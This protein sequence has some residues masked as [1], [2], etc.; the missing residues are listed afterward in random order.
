ML[1]ILYSFRRCPY[2]MRAR[3]AL[4]YSCISYEHR[5]I[6]LRDRPK[7]L[8]ELSPKGTVPVLNL[9][10]GKVLEESLDIM[11]WAINKN[12]PDD[13]YCKNKE[14]QDTLIRNNDQIFKNKLD[15]YKY[16]IRHTEK[17]FDEH[18]QNIAKL[19]SEHDDRLAQ[20]NYL[21]GDKITLA[22]V[23]IMPFIRQC[24]F[25]DKNWFDEEFIHLSNWLSEL[26]ESR[27]FTSV[28]HKYKIWQ[29]GSKGIIK[30]GN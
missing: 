27:L 8:Y 10:D 11:K 22:D 19:L 1:P 13:W 15:K 23:A 28:M 7:S 9:F 21:I 30:N 16:H 26:L 25:V 14:D 4:F 17:T 2:A 29:E 5:E 12:D 3:M 24:A 6:L 18:Q 20:N